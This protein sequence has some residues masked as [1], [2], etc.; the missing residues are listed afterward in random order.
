MILSIKDYQKKFYPDRAHDYVYNLIKDGNLPR[1]HV[2]TKVA[3]MWVISIIPFTQIEFA[4]RIEIACTAIWYHVK[5]QSD[6]DYKKIFTVELIATY[7][8]KYGVD[9]EHLK[10]VFGL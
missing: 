6:F 9:F 3:N 5:K 2:P 8:L 10:K 1:N 4:E 7:A